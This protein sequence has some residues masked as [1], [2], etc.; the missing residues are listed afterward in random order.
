[1]LNNR[2]PEDIREYVHDSMRDAGLMDRGYE[3]DTSYRLGTAIS[4]PTIT[5]YSEIYDLKEIVL[6]SRA[7]GV[8]LQRYEEMLGEYIGQT[9]VLKD[10]RLDNVAI[11]F[12]NGATAATMTI[13]GGPIRFPPNLTITDNN[14]VVVAK[15][16]NVPSMKRNENKA[17][18]QIVSSGNTSIAPNTLTKIKMN[19]T[20]IENIDLNKAIGVS[21]IVDQPKEIPIQIFNLSDNDRRYIIT[22]TAQGLAGGNRA[23]IDAVLTKLPTVVRYKIKEY[24]HGNGS[25][26][27]LVEPVD[28]TYPDSTIKQVEIAIK[29]IVSSGVRVI[30]QTPRLSQVTVDVFD[31]NGTLEDIYTNI[32]SL[33]NN[34]PMGKGI[35]V[36]EIRQA[37]N[38]KEVRVYKDGR[39]AFETVAVLENEKLVMNRE[40]A[41]RVG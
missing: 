24:Q 23:S 37:A 20:G 1:M 8:G 13:D 26:N 11:Q 4:V 19:V 5:A 28:L 41:V 2:T 9:F 14:E 32:A 17:Y 34:L 10:L 38:A 31:T 15:I 12:S 36:A 39:E 16:I 3:D 30:V 22:R 7:V 27:V 40:G 18:C 6:P 35:T 25:L 21:L 33:I 29:K